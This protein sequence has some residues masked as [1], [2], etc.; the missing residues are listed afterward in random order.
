MNYCISFS[1]STYLNGFEAFKFITRFVNFPIK[2]ILYTGVNDFLRYDYNKIVEQLSKSKIDSFNLAS[3]YPDFLA[4]KNLITFRQELHKLDIFWIRIEHSNNMKFDELLKSAADKDFTMML[5]FDMPKAHWQ[6]ERLID[7]YKSFNREYEHLPKIW[8]NTLSPILG[9]LI[10]ISKNPGHWVE[11]QD[12]VLMA[13]PK[14]WFGPGSWK[15]FD[16]E[17]VMSFPKAKEIKEVLPDV[18]YVNLFD[19]EE[20]DYESKKILGLQK[21]FREWTRMDE[22]EQSLSKKK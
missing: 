11:T 17:Q 14:M 5:N 4:S 21:E 10:D 19:A 12:F 20:P 3:D 2:R 18:V 1:H 6:S 13:A 15:L 22:I 7:N 9:E 8:D 16:K